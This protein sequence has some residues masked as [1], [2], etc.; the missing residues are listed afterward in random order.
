MKVFVCSHANVDEAGICYVLASCYASA[1]YMAAKHFASEGW[2][3]VEFID[4]RARLERSKVMCDW[5]ESFVND[6]NEPQVVFDDKMF[7][8]KCEG[9]EGGLYYLM[10]GD[11]SHACAIN[12]ED[13]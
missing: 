5:V 2:D 3:D 4:I 6:K 12:E 9:S 8:H 13:E 11:K 7:C 10:H 1:K